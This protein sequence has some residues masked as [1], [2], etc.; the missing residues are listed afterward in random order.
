M[1]AI[2]MSPRMSKNK[3]EQREKGIRKHD[4]YGVVF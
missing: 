3:I 4:A 2:D 1:N